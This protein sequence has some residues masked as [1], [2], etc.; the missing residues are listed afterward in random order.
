M[1]FPLEVFAAKREVWP[2][3]KPMTARISATDWVEGGLTGEDAVAV[4]A[5]LRDAGRGR[6]RRLHRSG[7]PRRA[8]CLRPLVPGPFADAI[9]NRLGLAT[10][11]VGVISSYDEVNSVL[12][13]GRADLCAMGRA[14]LY[15]PSWTPHAAAE[16]DYDG[17]GA[18][19]LLP[20]RAG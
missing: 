3:H 1:R 14:H 4:A 5:L 8:A 20:W 17:D 7:H 12:L 19:G 6:H 11:A 13:S 10:I 15:D 2:D 9:R 16:Q 18:L